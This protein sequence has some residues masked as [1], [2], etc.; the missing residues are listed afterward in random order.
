[1]WTSDKCTS[2]VVSTASKMIVRKNKRILSQ[3]R[4]VPEEDGKLK[5]K[6]KN[7]NHQVVVWLLCQLSDNH[8]PQ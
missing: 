4:L 1:M 2:G 5:K 8:H 3:G 7:D 6:K